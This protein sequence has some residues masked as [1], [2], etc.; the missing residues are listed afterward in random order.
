MYTDTKCKVVNNGWISSSITLQRGIR[1][2]CPLSALL[3][4]LTVET[5]AARIRQNKNIEGILLHKN[6]EKDFKI[7]QLADDATLFLRNKRSITN[8]LNL[9]EF[10]L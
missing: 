4:V 6:Q 9:I 2:G 1:Q 8:A 10:F 5:M 7:A 3:F